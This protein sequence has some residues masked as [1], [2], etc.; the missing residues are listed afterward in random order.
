MYHANYEEQK[1]QM[2]EGIELPNQ[3]KVRTLGEKDTNKY[4]GI[5]EA[6]TI[7]QLKMKEKNLKI[8]QENGK[9]TRNQTK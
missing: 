4:L 3:E 2:T 9:A 8:A 5:L 1:R 6:N 7:K